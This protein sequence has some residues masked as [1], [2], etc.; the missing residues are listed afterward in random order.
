MSFQEDNWQHIMSDRPEI[1]TIK[2]AENYYLQ[3]DGVV[4]LIEEEQNMMLRKLEIII[5]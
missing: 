3:D 5:I 2:K 4:L 1:K